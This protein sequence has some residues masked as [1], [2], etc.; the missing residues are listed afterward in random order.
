[1]PAVAPTKSRLIVLRD[2]SD[3]TETIPKPTVLIDTREQL[4]L[5]FDKFNNW[6]GG[7]RTATLATGDY[8]IE[9]MEF[10]L[11]LERKSLNDVVTTLTHNRQRFIRQL[12]R[13]KVMPYKAILIEA[14]YEDVKSPYNFTED[15]VAHPNGVSG[16]L[17]AIELRYGIPVIYTSRNRALATEKAASWLSKAYTYWWLESKGMGRVLQE[18]DL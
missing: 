9:G 2:G 15:T 18:G 6:I 17:D 11:C 5:N 8:S 7:S 12:E 4:P 1:M 14:S 10:L 3:I 16:S 13:M